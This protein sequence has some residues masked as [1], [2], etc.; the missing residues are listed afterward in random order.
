MPTRQRWH[1]RRSR[2]LSRIEQLSVSCEGT[3]A[4]RFVEVLLDLGL[5]EIFKGHRRKPGRD[6]LAG[7]L[8]SGLQVLHGHS[9]ALVAYVVRVLSDQHVDVASSQ[10]LNLC[11]RGIEGYDAHLVLFARLP[12]PGSGALPSK[13][14]GAEDSFQ[15]GVRLEG[16]GGDGRRLGRII[17]AVLGSEVLDVRI[18]LYRL[19]EALFPLV[20]SG[21]AGLDADNHNF[22]LFADLLGQSLARLPAS[23]DVVGGDFRQRDLFLLDGR[24]HQHHSYV[25][26]DGTLY[27]GDHGGHVGRRDEDG[28]RVGL[29]CRVQ[30]GRLLGGGELLGSLHL[31]VGP[32]FLSRGL[33]PA[34]HGGVELVA[35][36]AHD[37]VESI[38]LAS[39]LAAATTRPE[40]RH[41]GAR[42]SN[43]EELPTRDPAPSFGS[44]T[45]V[46]SFP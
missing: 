4:L 5:V 23:Q 7:R 2:W 30:D 29:D 26:I 38:A 40:K 32:Q 6:L 17:V 16:G 12:N 14:V 35:G 28:I 25:L 21:N 34:L 36:D 45:Q 42:G 31:Q 24:I 3:L 41:P 44:L 43:T 11:R 18:F 27:R 15:I 9:D 1:E 37:Q 22:A 20:G 33:R 10:V 39:S 19:L 46:S 8:L 13:D